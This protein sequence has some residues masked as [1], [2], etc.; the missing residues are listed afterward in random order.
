MYV[1]VWCYYSRPPGQGVRYNK[2]SLYQ[3]AFFTYILP[4]LGLRKESVTPRTSLY[5]SSSYRLL[6]P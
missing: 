1:I 2:A 4:F 6:R 3:D 5:R